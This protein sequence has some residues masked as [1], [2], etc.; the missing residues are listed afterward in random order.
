MMLGVAGASPRWKGRTQRSAAVGR[1]S[2]L[3]NE[4]IKMT[5]NVNFVRLLNFIDVSVKI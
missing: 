5:F 2:S 1:G 4:I 3:K